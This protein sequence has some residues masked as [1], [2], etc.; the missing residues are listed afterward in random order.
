V[1]DFRA[2]GTCL[3]ALALPVAGAAGEPR[4]HDGG[5]FLRLAPGAGY[6][7]TGLTEDGDRLALKGLTGNFDMA[8]G[9]V[10]TK[11][12]ALHATLGG[13]GLVDPTVQFNGLS[14]T[15]DDASVTMVMFGAGLTYYL[16]RS[17]TYLTASAG[18]STLTLDF[19]GDRSDSDTGFAFEAGIGKEWW[20]SDRWGIGL[21]GTA[22]YH[23][24]PPGD[25]STNFSGPSFAV[26][27]S[28]TFN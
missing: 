23:S 11:N 14:E 25:A 20:V 27:F 15:A 1:L 10:V 6:A 13:W 19:E 24:I 12:L 26:R 21:S 4:A 5:F 17:N 16:G 18:A 22:G 8:I 9:A 3:L 2:A 28:A 7:R